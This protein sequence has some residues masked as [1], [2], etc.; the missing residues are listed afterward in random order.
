LPALMIYMKKDFSVLCH[1]TEVGTPM[2]HII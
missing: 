2:L 1:G